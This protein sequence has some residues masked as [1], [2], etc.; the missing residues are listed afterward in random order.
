VIAVAV[1]CVAAAIVLPEV[2]THLFHAAC[3]GP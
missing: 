2:P 1:A 3:R